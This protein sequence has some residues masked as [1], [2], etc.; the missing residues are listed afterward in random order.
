MFAATWG[1]ID[2]TLQRFR[3]VLVLGILSFLILA[4]IHLKW[5]A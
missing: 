1:V 3:Q 2:V 4:W 5:R